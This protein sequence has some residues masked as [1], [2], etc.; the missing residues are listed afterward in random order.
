M[1]TARIPILPNKLDAPI[2]TDPNPDPD[3][4]PDLGPNPNTDPDSNPELNPDPDPIPNLPDRPSA[5]TTKRFAAE[6][7][8]DVLEPNRTSTLNVL[9]STPSKTASKTPSKTASKTAAASKPTAADVSV[10]A[11][12]QYE[13]KISE[14]ST[15]PKRE[16][17]FE[18]SGFGKPGLRRIDNSNQIDN[19][20]KIGNTKVLIIYTIGSIDNT[21]DEHTHIHRSVVC[22]NQQNSWK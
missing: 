21:D 3:P 15:I 4:G 1:G 5:D 6:K 7:E 8:R 9:S 20:L 22:G 16:N 17:S 2:N 13:K 19:F 10:S 11:K 12:I 18:L 14:K